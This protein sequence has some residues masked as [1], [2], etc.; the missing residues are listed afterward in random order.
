MSH[1]QEG[2]KWEMGLDVVE[3]CIGRKLMASQVPEFGLG[4]LETYPVSLGFVE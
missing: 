4:F 1:L 2:F 3:R